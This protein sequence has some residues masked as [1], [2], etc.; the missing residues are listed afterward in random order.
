MA[1]SWARTLTVSAAAAALQTD[2]PD[3][4]VEL[5]T[6]ELTDLPLAAY[7]NFQ[8]LMNLVPGA[9]PG[10]LQNSINDTP[11]RDFLANVNGTNGNGNNVHLDGA[12]DKMN[13]INSHIMYVPPAESIETVKISTNSFDA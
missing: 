5:A 4:H 2:K 6:K 10:A 8:S 13:I 12:L 7:R 3:V 9:T 1:A 11:Q